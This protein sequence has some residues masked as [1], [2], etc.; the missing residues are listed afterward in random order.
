MEVSAEQL[1]NALAKRV[2]TVE[3][4]KYAVFSLEQPQKA[5]YAIVVI[6]GNDI[7]VRP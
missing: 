3:V 1:E 2:G 4:K 5:E 6:F 7:V